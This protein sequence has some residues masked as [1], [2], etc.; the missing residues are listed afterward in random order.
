MNLSHQP[1][2][3]HIIDTLGNELRPT[4]RD[5]GG[6]VSDIV[7]DISPTLIRVVSQ[8]GAWN[9]DTTTTVTV[10]I[11][12]LPSY[13]YLLSANAIILKD[14]LVGPAY[15]IDTYVD[16]VNVLPQ[17]GIGEITDAHVVLWRKTGGLF[18]SIDFDH[19]TN[20]RGFIFLEYR[21]A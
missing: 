9:M 18:D 14:G 11:A 10:A 19:P 20:N 17:G 15:K 1:A 3:D 8:I 2:F 12:D 6:G 21:H 7:W 16:A 4:K 5:C 13:A